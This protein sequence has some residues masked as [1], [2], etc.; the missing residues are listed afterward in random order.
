[1]VS[2]DPSRRPT[3]LN[4]KPDPSRPPA[5]AAE[6]LAH[7]YFSNAPPPTPRAQLPKPPLR[8]DNPLQGPQ[9]LKPAVKAAT[10]QGEPDASARPAK[11]R[12]IDA[13]GAA[14]PAS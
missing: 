4:P 14:S 5:A 10:R 9:G 6:A 2:L 7:P 12:R 11:Q 8:E 3:G 1:M 13:A